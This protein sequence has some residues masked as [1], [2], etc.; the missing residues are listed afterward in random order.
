MSTAYFWDK[1]AFLLNDAP[2][3]QVG[4]YRTV[5]DKLRAVRNA[6]QLN[7]TYGMV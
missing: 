2:G 7:K 3:N 4:I 5:V 6:K 1:T